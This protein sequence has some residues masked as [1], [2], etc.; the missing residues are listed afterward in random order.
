[1]SPSNYPLTA[2]LHSQAFRFQLS[3]HFKG[4]PLAGRQMN[5]PGLTGSAGPIIEW[6]TEGLTANDSRRMLVS[7]WKNLQAQ[8][9]LFI[10]SNES[11]L[12]ACA[13]RSD[14]DKSYRWAI[15]WWWFKWILCVF[16]VIWLEYINLASPPKKTDS[17]TQS[18]CTGRY[19]VPI[20]CNT[21]LI[22]SII[23][24]SGNIHTPLCFLGLLLLSVFCRR[25]M[26]LQHYKDHLLL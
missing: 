18:Q 8:Q 22:S 14:R 26:K 15:M 4:Q 6:S 10:N 20:Y 25:F 21:I 5:S 12:Q 17:V 7:S 9:I 16:S 11:W 23:H 19:Q 2:C 3:Q 1:M 24:L 13:L